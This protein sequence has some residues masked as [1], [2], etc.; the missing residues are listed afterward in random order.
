ML[1]ERRLQTHGKVIY[2]PHSHKTRP[3]GENESVACF[4]SS[5]QRE[6]EREKKTTAGAA[7][8]T[9]ERLAVNV[10]SVFTGRGKNSSFLPQLSTAVT[11]HHYYLCNFHT[12]AFTQLNHPDESPQSR[13]M[14]ER[15]R[16]TTA[17]HGTIQH[18]R[19]ML[20]LF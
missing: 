17:V 18:F 2:C 9:K 8:F 10:F 4:H 11:H 12:L 14:P 7:L 19:L 3:S 6:R 1:T 16:D 15:S 20:Q 13:S 5:E